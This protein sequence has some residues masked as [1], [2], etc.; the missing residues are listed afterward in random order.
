MYTN[1]RA[2]LTKLINLLEIRLKRTRLISRPLT[3]TLEPTLRCNSNCIMCNRNFN[4][5]EDKAS[6]GFLS[7]EILNK[8]KPFFRHAKS[9]LFG[10]FGE[11]LMHPDYIPMLKEIKQEGPFVFF[12]TN[13]I[14]L[15]E[16]TGVALANGGIDRISISM[17]GATR[18]T[19]HKIRG[20]DA[21]DQV[22]ENIQ[23]LDAYKKKRNLKKPVLA[24]NVVAMNSI[25]EEFEALIHLAKRLGVESVTMP[26]MVVQGDS[27]MEESIWHHEERARESIQRTAA[28][29]K[30]MGIHYA[31]PNLDRCT[32]D[33]H[34]F[35]KKFAINWDGTVMSCALERYIVG[36]LKE[37][38]MEEIW[39]GPGMR[40]LRKR[41]FEEGIQRVCP[42]CFCWDNRPEAYFHPSKNAREFAEKLF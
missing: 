29:A 13:G 12:F 20:V 34:E 11:A 42:N 32:V 8:A 28:L 9:V 7:W 36:D 33:C 30:A 15:T 17:G 3:I 23:R 27:L 6:Q 16:E 5:K 31:P 10:G 18:S 4:R 37:N 22:V 26:N 38:T 21:F 2:V 35:F 14:L 1:H 40:G 25:L 19:F 39:N 24:F 41:Y